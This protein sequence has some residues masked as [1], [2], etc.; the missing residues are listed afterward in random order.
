MGD[1]R[2]VT[3]SSHANGTVRTEQEEVGKM[4]TIRYD[5]LFMRSL[6]TCITTKINERFLIII[7]IIITLLLIRVLVT[8]T[9]R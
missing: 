6:V 9:R 7:I 3:S 8:T 5:A 1:G 2:K 4:V